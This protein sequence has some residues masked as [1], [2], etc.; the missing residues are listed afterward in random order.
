MWPIALAI[1]GMSWLI[2]HVFS[3]YYN[4]LIV[5][6]IPVYDVGYNETN[7]LFCNKM[8]FCLEK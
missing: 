6:V 5:F 3:C 2:M 4:N 7:D 1:T 8:P